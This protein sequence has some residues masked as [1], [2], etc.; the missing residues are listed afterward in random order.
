[1]LAQLI[2]RRAHGRVRG[3]V[4][5]DARALHV[6]LLDDALEAELAEDVGLG[7]IL[8]PVRH[9]GDH[10]EPRRRLAVARREPLEELRLV[11]LEHVELARPRSVVE[12]AERDG[13]A[14]VEEL[15]RQIE[16][17]E[18]RRTSSV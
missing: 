13:V 9:A 1:M 4:G 17:I 8:A 10:D 6:Q 5:V 7:P 3:R 12:V 14:C 18:R 15:G 11:A 2:E 16:P